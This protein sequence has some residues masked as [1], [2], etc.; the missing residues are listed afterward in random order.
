MLTILLPASLT[1]SKLYIFTFTTYSQINNTNTFCEYN[2][3]AN[4]K[5]YISEKK[6]G[7]KKRISIDTDV[8][9][10]LIR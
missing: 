7:K 10:L 4:K 5:E 2:F 3:F 8:S 1:L 9:M 6:S